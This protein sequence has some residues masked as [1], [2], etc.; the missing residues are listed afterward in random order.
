MRIFSKIDFL[1]T[2]EAEVIIL[3]S[4]VHFSVYK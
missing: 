4:Y 2:V 3:T 1:N